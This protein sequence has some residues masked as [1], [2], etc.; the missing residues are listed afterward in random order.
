MER[1]KETD[2]SNHA[3]CSFCQKNALNSLKTVKAGEED[4]GRPAEEARE[5]ER[6]GGLIHDP[7]IAL[8]CKT[9][10]LFF[11]ESPGTKLQKFYRS[12]EVGDTTSTTTRLATISMTAIKATMKTL[13]RLAGNF[14]RM[15]Q[16]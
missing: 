12:T 7:N 4:T 6:V 13:P 14:P 1:D 15:I 8:I 11:H 5:R 9:F 16:C 2:M 10:Q 3:R